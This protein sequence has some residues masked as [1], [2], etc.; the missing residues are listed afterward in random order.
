MA[1][2]GGAATR[3]PA[4]STT[5]SLRLKTWRDDWLGALRFG[6]VGC[7]WLEGD[8]GHA[9]VWR[10]VAVL[11]DLHISCLLFPVSNFNT[12]LSC[13]WLWLGLLFY[14]F[15]FYVQCHTHYTKHSPISCLLFS[16]CV[17]TDCVDTCDEKRQ[18]NMLNNVATLIAG[19]QQHVC[20]SYRLASSW[21][22]TFLNLLLPLQ[23][24][25]D[26]TCFP[27]KHHI[28]VST[29]NTFLSCCWLR[30]HYDTFVIY[31]H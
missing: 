21:L 20:S 31:L 11:P 12:C 25:Q 6:W 9:G 8:G 16:C 17:A 13:C 5:P 15:Y 1:T 18:R 22:H 7:F 2:T 3:N 14:L 26:I 30:Q 29:F 19:V 10:C 24:Q 28:P 4:V 27:F 23:A